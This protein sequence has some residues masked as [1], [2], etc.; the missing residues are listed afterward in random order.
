MLAHSVMQPAIRHKKKDVLDLPPITFETREI[1]LSKEQEKHY[2]LMEKEYLTFL[3][4]GEVVTAAN[5]AVKYIKLLQISCG[6]II[7]QD[8]E[9][10]SINHKSRLDELKL[11]IGQ[12][13]KLIVFATFTKSI[14]TLV[15]E[16]PGSEKIDGSVS[17]KNRYD[18]IT[19]FQEGDLKVLICQS[20]AISHGVTLTAAHTIV[21]WSA[22]FSNEV[23]KQC[24]GRIDRPGQTHNQLI[25]K[26]CATKAE[27]RV[28]SALRRKEKV[29]QAML[30]YKNE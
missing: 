16:I 5:A 7:N 26:F 18:I 15:N 28:F 4:S 17:S 13:D 11:I 2:K 21:L 29:S 3:D 9:A 22:P 27:K 10:I 14:N 12:V 1:Q 30:N 20:A 19:R 24:I 23:Y 25:I 6:L 8:G